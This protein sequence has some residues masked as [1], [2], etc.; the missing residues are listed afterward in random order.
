MRG[1]TLKTD[2]QDS[3]LC[4]INIHSKVKQQFFTFV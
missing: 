4:E 1:E 3:T 2:K